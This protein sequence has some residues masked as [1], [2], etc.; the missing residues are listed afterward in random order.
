MSVRE[1]QRSPPAG[2]PADPIDERTPL[3]VL[4]QV[5]G[6]YHFRGHQ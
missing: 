5:F 2:M 3:G 1:N 4:R 6:F